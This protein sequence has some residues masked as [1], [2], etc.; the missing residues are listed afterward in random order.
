MERGG[1]DRHRDDSRSTKISFFTS[2]M[3]FSFLD[4]LRRACRYDR[5]MAKSHPWWGVY[6]EAGRGEGYAM[7]G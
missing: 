5:F 1:A 2:S 3:A 6:E 4:R 7:E